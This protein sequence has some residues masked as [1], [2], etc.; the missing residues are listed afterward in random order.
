MFCY[1]V[2]MNKTISLHLVPRSGILPR[3]LPVLSAWLEEGKADVI[4][5]AFLFNPYNLANHLAANGLNPQPFLERLNIQRAFTCYQ[6]ETLLASLSPS[7]NPLLVLGLL[8]PFEDEAVRLAERRRLLN[9]ALAA[10]HRR[11]IVLIYECSF[12]V[13]SDLLNLLRHSADI[14]VEPPEAEQV[15]QLRLF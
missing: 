7:P 13:P 8:M 10:L 11:K 6:V 9:N 14:V 3:A 2:Y 12:K 15:E 4:D 5:A 1:N